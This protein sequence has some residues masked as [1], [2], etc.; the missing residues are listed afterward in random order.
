MASAL[1]MGSSQR[2]AARMSMTGASGQARQRAGRVNDGVIGENGAMALQ[3][4]RIVLWAAMLLVVFWLVMR[5]SGTLAPFVFGAILTYAL[6]PAVDLVAR[7]IPARS[8]RGDVYRRGFVV[9]LLYL[10]MGGLVFLVG[11]FIVPAAVQQVTQFVDELPRL[12]NEAR[13]EVQDW[14]AQYRATVPLE[15]Q[16][17]LDPLI[18]DWTN[19][20]TA[21]VATWLR[22]S[23][24]FITQTLVLV[25]AL[26][27]LPFW[28]FYAL[29][30]RHFVARNFMNAVPPA[31]RRDV[32]NVLLMS[33]RILG[34]Y[35]R[36]Q[37]LL[38]L[39]VGVAVGVGLTLMGVQLSLALG[40]WAG[41]TELIP[42]IGPWLGAI[43]ALIIV[44]S[45]DPGLFVWVALLYVAVQQLENNL[46]VPRIQGQAVD[47]HPAMIILLL[48]VA[49]TVFGF[50]GL[51]V[52]VPVAAIL[53]EL[54]WYTDHRLRGQSP[55]EALAAGQ[56]GRAMRRRAEEKRAAAAR[57]PDGVVPVTDGAAG[58]V[59][60]APAEPARAE[61]ARAEPAAPD[62]GRPDAAG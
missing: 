10:A 45:T 40:V 50:I 32:Q 26:L 39:V 22:R 18:E 25:V 49:A 51:V 21:A 2:R 59:V 56:V 27:V 60:R 42:I 20:A 14:L 33:D 57:Q 53:R 54:F 34:R 41:I 23:V 47:I 19:A 62:P 46:L 6:T 48:A 12:V 58:A 13:D 36:G 43:P 15:L 1:G 28:M 9:L 4:W 30:D 55:N 16:N 38:G 35:I 5:A 52:V 31:L 11:A 24:S 7:I 61:P 8:H 3:H 29:R 37:L 17:R 44:L